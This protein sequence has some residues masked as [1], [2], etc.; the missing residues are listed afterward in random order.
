MITYILGICL[1]TTLVITIIIERQLI[2]AQK[3]RIKQLHNEISRL[4]EKLKWM[5]PWN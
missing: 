3:I 1:G 5:L 2:K 4:K